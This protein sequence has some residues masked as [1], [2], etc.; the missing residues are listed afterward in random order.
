MLPSMVGAA[1]F[2]CKIWQH[3]APQS[4]S[5][6]RSEC[7]KYPVLTPTSVLC[8]V[9]LQRWCAQVRDGDGEETS[10]RAAQLCTDV[11]VVAVTVSPNGAPTVTV[12][13]TMTGQSESKDWMAGN[14]V[15]LVDKVSGAVLQWV[16]TTLLCCC[17]LHC[18]VICCCPLCYYFLC[19]CLLF[20]CYF[21][22]CCLLCC[23]FL[24]CLL[25]C[26][27]FVQSINCHRCQEGLTRPDPIFGTVQHAPKDANE[28]TGTIQ[29]PG[30][31]C[32]LP[33]LP[34]A[35]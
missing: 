3:P 11:S 14:L 29:L 25:L 17:L 21:L 34:S 15:M 1:L 12:C 8:A 28:V 4:I 24:C 13:F 9:Y 33:L 10:I 27:R 7:H 32:V 35:N 19:C 31:H 20:C 5:V 26:C 18:Q 2:V 23:Y 16:L 22:C 30:V 6:T